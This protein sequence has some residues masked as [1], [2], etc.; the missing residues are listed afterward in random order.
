M[1]SAIFLCGTDAIMRLALLSDIHANARA[2]AACLAHAA[3]QGTTHHALLGDVVGYG[4]EPGVVVARAMEL[5]AQGAVVLRGNH[6]ALALSPPARAAT[7]EEGSAAWTHDQLGVAQRDFLAGLP[8]QHRAA[9]LLLVHASADEP[10]A[11]HYV[12]NPRRAQASLDAAGEE[13]RYLFVGHV[14]HQ[15]VFYQG[16]G[17]GLMHF[18]PAAGVALP[19]PPHRRWLMTV[20]SVGQPRDGRPQAMYAIWDSDA[21]QVVFHRVAYDHLGAAAAIRAAGLPEQFARRL[22]EGR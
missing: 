3:A 10:Q 17:R 18:E 2:F 1:L 9:P 19:A 13:V 4:A 14:H 16:A 5:A 12:D 15:G 22:E 6:D 21:A 7:M 20:G 11:W 8:L